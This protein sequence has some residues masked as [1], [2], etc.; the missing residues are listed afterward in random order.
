M[1]ENKKSYMAGIIPLPAVVGLALGA[2]NA[3]NFLSSNSANLNPFTGGKADR[4]TM[5][6]RDIAPSTQ[7]LVNKAQTASRL[8][9]SQSTM[10]FKKR[11][12]SM[13]SKAGPERQAVIAAYQTILNSPYL[14]LSKEEI[15]DEKMQLLVASK[16]SDDDLV[17]DI[18]SRIK[19]RMTEFGADNQDE[20]FEVFRKEVQSQL[21]LE[22]VGMTGLP[23]LNLEHPISSERVYR[24]EAFEQ[25]GDLGQRIRKS[26]TQLEKIAGNDYE[27]YKVHDT[28]LGATAWMAKIRSNHA[29]FD[30][31]LAAGRYVLGANGAGLN[32]PAGGFI[33]QDTSNKGKYRSAVAI[34]SY[35]SNYT[36]APIAPEDYF[37]SQLSSSLKRARGSHSLQRRAVEQE[38]AA[39]T[40]DTG[41]RI[42][43]DFNSAQRA[44]LILSTYSVTNRIPGFRPGNRYDEE[45][46][47]ANQHLQS[48]G[49]GY[50]Q[51]ATGQR[52]VAGTPLPEL[53]PPGGQVGDLSVTAKSSSLRKT[54]II[55]NESVI[56]N[57]MLGWTDR[58]FINMKASTPQEEALMLL[59]NSARRVR[60]VIYQLDTKNS[61]LSKYKL[62]GYGEG[63]YLGR[64][65]SYSSIPTPIKGIKT[66]SGTE[67]LKMIMSSKDNEVALT[68]SQMRKYGGLLGRT[69]TGNVAKVALDN[70]IRKIRFKVLP[71]EN[72]T[73]NLS[74]QTERKAGRFSKVRGHTIKGQI[75]NT[76]D[77]I[78]L[79]EAARA[80]GM[81]IDKYKSVYGNI[82]SGI[83]V[84][85]ADQVLRQPMFLKNQ[86]IS[87]FQDVM[88]ARGMSFGDIKNTTNT[89][90]YQLKTN[91]EWASYIARTMEGAGASNE[92][93]VSVLAGQYHSFTKEANLN[94]LT[95]IHGN[96]SALKSA[97]ESAKSFIGLDTISLDT[98]AEFQ[99]A[100]KL[101]SIE[102]RTLHSLYQSLRSS[103][104]SEQDATKTLGNIISRTGNARSWKHL[105]T[106]QS[107]LVSAMS[108]QGL[109]RLSDLENLGQRLGVGFTMS[110][111]SV[112]SLTNV[113][114]G[115]EDWFKNSTMVKFKFDS[116][117]TSDIA[118]K[119]FGTDE[120]LIPGLQ[121][122]P[123][124]HTI[125]TKKGGQK[126]NIGL[127]YQ[128]SL[129]RLL[130]M[131]QDPNVD[132]TQIQEEMYSMKS[133]IYKLSS[134]SS[135]S[136]ITGK[137]SGS[138]TGRS[139]ML[140][141]IQHKSGYEKMMRLSKAD[142]YQTVF[143]SDRS[144]FTNIASH[145]NF[146][147]KTGTQSKDAEK[148]IVE[149]T[150][151]WLFESGKKK[152]GIFGFG[153]RHPSLGEGHAQFLRARRV[154]DHGQ[155]Q[156][157]LKSKGIKT[158][159]EQKFGSSDKKIFQQFLKGEIGTQ[160]NQRE[161]SSVVIS[162]LERLKKTGDATFYVP[163]VEVN[164]KMN[165]KDEV[166]KYNP[167]TRA[168]ADFDGDVL[169]FIMA[170]K[171]T[172]SAFRDSMKNG[173]VTSNFLEGN[174][175]F[176]AI[177]RHIKNYQDSKVFG[178]SLSL[179]DH[180][181][182]DVLKMVHSKNVQKF[183]TA[184][185]ALKVG[186]LGKGGDAIKNKRSIQV[187]TILEEIMLKAKKQSMALNIAD[188]VAEAIFKGNKDKFFSILREHVLPEDQGIIDLEYHTAHATSP[189]KIAID[190]NETFEYIWDN[191]TTLKTEGG[192]ELKNI[193][194]IV[195]KID[196]NG[197]N[198]KTTKRLNKLINN[199]YYGKGGLIQGMLAEEAGVIE[200]TSRTAL[201][202]TTKT[203]LHTVRN[204]ATNKKIIGPAA[205][206]IGA[207]LA[208]SNFMNKDVE[209]EIIDVESQPRGNQEINPAIRENFLESQ[210]PQPYQYV[211]SDNIIR[212]ETYAQDG[213]QR[214]E[215]TFT[216][217]S[218]LGPVKNIIN[219][220]NLN[221]NQIYIQDNRRPITK[222]TID[223]LREM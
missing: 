13:L 142:N 157:L 153:G 22:K 43:Q 36:D 196:F 108:M 17:A 133:L 24:K 189:S 73:V 87:A 154:L 180:I 91:E 201:A 42:A 29:S 88:S 27:I 14:A 56:L 134:E 122:V 11:F 187:L 197:L 98:G 6:G 78:L 12:E 146:L 136:R 101:A 198:Q 99:G 188:D 100:G 167:F 18:S 148:E 159:L 69:E 41:Q 191:Y 65:L 3:R 48:L 4:M 143:M 193:K 68:M 217:I 178:K 53:M 33:F 162:R 107:F 80:Q 10:G 182:E 128:A 85:D 207:T 186:V 127:E 215:S 61:A 214:I 46:L 20:F 110:K 72:G 5:I 49:V 54:N 52:F 202:D 168:Y 192:M 205:I 118:K 7:A 140:N 144:F 9:I 55:T 176:N 147:L 1:E 141:K 103:G 158:F 119:V 15:E 171:G 113:N 40:W 200:K 19:K 63:A 51:L 212:Q 165:G 60:K 114:L 71:G 92:E 216:G 35:I 75:V 38:F 137:V 82:A 117:K 204:I 79:E 34:G 221:R 115:V 152:G 125:T 112:T 173:Q 179:T 220:L 64:T 149:L 30:V 170:D 25:T 183:S 74:Y 76:P 37:L 166:L 97:L 70:S 83:I 21:K 28:R 218:N 124:L 62:G 81:S 123:S 39:S 150:K 175:E 59:N 67:L 211:Q 120:V 32:L 16:K 31:P 96:N 164:Y 155:N 86:M 50:S 185:D 219:T 138:T 132:A 77:A 131:S 172:V 90:I 139:W 174:I 44:N 222:N 135:L 195:N 184:L 213:A 57:P 206:G 203:L 121:G 111:R 66:D 109:D 130:K 145:K 94:A 106:S 210:A 104:L 190:M 93:I 156:E 84:S 199:L 23:T 177:K 2:N 163:N 116:P 161:F 45:K 8:F 160:E 126:V 169:S 223:Q 105:Y 95:K 102:R 89:L 209:P 58:S 151:N 26:L 208:L 129:Q 47:I 181:L 194:A